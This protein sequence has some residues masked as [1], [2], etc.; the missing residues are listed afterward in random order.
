MEFKDLNLDNIDLEDSVSSSKEINIEGGNYF[1]T[2]TMYVPFGI[3]N[4]KTTYSINLQF[5]NINVNRELQEFLE[6]IKKFER[7]LIKKLKISEEQFNSQ[8]KFHNKY[9]PMLN[10]KFIF[11]FNKIECDVKNHKEYLNIFDIGK[12]FSCRC[13]LY[14]D[15]VWLYKGKYSC[16]L[17]VKEIF[18]KS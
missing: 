12:N 6:F 7:N 13:L 1:Y 9:D 15:K 5:R 14:I 17:K 11:K 3:E 10:T 18:I 4:Y 8:L 2:P 16:K